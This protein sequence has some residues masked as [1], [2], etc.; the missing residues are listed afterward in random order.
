MHRR[1]FHKLDF[2]DILVLPY[3]TTFFFSWSYSSLLSLNTKQQQQQPPRSAADL[4]PH[5]NGLT[6]SPSGLDDAYIHEEHTQVPI[7]TLFIWIRTL[8]PAVPGSNAVRLWVRTTFRVSLS[9]K[10]EPE[11]APKTPSFSSLLF[12]SSLIIYHFLV[13]LPP[14]PKLRSQPDIPSFV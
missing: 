6:H 11:E 5:T 9:K 4:T 10:V 14:P 13:L 8:H 1:A 12:P 3:L 2:T 7:L